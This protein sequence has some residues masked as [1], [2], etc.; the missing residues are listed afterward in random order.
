MKR[1]QVGYMKQYYLHLEYEVYTDHHRDQQ[2]LG[3][4][5]FFVRAKHP[6]V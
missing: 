2:E 5:C 1:S 6:H 4:S 3:E